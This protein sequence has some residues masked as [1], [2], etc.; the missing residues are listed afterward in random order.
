MSNN[1]LLLTIF[2][3]FL[4]SCGGYPRLLNSSFDTGGRSL[5]SPAAE[6]EPEI[7]AN[8]IVFVSDRGGSQDV[9]L[10]NTAQKKLVN[11]PGLNSLDAIA[12][13]PSISEDGRYIVFTASRQGRRGVY[14]YDRET[15]QSRNLT[16]NLAAEVRN[17]SISADG[18]T[19]A[20]EANTDGQ[21]D[22]LVYESSGKR[23]E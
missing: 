15:T 20:F 13:H 22:I 16:N 14:L 21:W 6:L 9:Y 10:Y 3:S 1:Y 8:H 18:S 23:L 2:S 19:I 4:V 12:S 11:L 7:S 17:P 5:N